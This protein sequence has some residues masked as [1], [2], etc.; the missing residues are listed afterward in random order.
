VQDRQA[1]TRALESGRA[2]GYFMRHENEAAMELLRYPA[3]ELAGALLEATRR[4][5]ELENERAVEVNREESAEKVQ[6][7]SA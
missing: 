3:D 1:A 4:Y 6:G 2:Q 7:A 5:V